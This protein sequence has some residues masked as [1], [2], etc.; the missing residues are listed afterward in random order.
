MI[1]PLPP[2]A[3]PELMAVC[4]PLLVHSYCE[5]LEYGME[6]DAEALLS[7]WKWLYLPLYSNELRDLER[8]NTTTKIVLLNQQIITHKE[9][10]GK[11][12]NAKAQLEKLKSRYAVKDQLKHQ[13]LLNWERKVQEAVKTESHYL[14]EIQSYPFL[15]RVRTSRMQISLSAYTYSLL[16]AF[17][18]RE[19][20]I[21][22]SVLL[23]TKCHLSVE[24]R[25]PLPYTPACVLVDAISNIPEESGE[26]AETG[27][28]PNEGEATKRL[29]PLPAV[30]LSVNQEMVRWAAPSA[31]SELSA[32]SK[33][34]SRAAFPPLSDFN[35]SLL[36][37]GFRRLE[38]LK[39]KQE[40]ND[41]AQVI[42]GDGPAV[43]ARQNLCD[44][45]SPSALLA[46]CCAS[47][48]SAR[49][50]RLE[51]AA[52]E[53][54]CA[55]LCPG[56]GRKIAVGCDD[57]AI[58]VWCLDGSGTAS[59]RKTSSGKETVDG[60]A[61][62]IGGDI[63]EAHVLLVG[64]KG[65]W[66]VFGVDFCK[67]GRSLISCGGDGT[68][69]LWDTAAVGPYGRL[70]KN[71]K[72][73]VTKRPLSKGAQSSKLLN[74]P[75]DSTSE[76]KRKPGVDIGGAA[77]CVY[78]GHSFNTPI[79]DCRFAPS[80][81]YFATCGGDTTGKIWTTDRPAPVRSLVGHL[82]SVNC[83]AWHPNVNYVVT[84]SDDK[85]CR[86]WDVQTG[87]CVR[88]LTG[89]HG[90]VTSLEVCPSGKYVAA[91]DGTGMIGMYDL[92]W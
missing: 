27:T 68:V 7:A 36:L 67:D 29:P 90:W 60:S 34:Y 8:C 53:I 76:T 15:H 46:T 42:R 70:A 32:G 72:K 19:R 63:S 14:R 59:T 84:G 51:S 30:S 92:A 16:A 24:P 64:H 1:P 77:L 69:R 74:T 71:V 65:G 38:A 56:D 57:S 55:K 28:P 48:S 26:E 83:V 66:P 37:N 25:D 3:K 11:L 87:R 10:H 45:L 91:A 17:M 54:T 18:A 62:L 50:G 33:E 86:M 22:M 41:E 52:V 89:F 39:I 31:N 9:Q 20:L 21:P 78:R 5:L 4:F 80:G 81:Y 88:V 12:R 47:S 43:A 13:L 44:A 23:M 6:A 35:R 61:P 85:T 79:W 2:S 40:H 73:A 49:G 82:S 75:G 58:R